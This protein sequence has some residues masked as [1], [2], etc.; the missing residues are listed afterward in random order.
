MKTRMQAKVEKASQYP[1]R[2]TKQMKVQ[3]QNGII[4]EL[5]E[6]IET[7]RIE[8]NELINKC[9][10]LQKCVP[11]EEPFDVLEVLYGLQDM[12]HKNRYDMMLLEI[13]KGIQ[14]LIDDGHVKNELYK[15]IENKK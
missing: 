1:K 4:A 2:I 8:H 3:K 13:R 15:I 5:K 7:K 11:T 10:D 12:L 14:E 6:R 9:K